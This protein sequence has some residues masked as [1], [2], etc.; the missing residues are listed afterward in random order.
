V[1][2]R[3]VRFRRPRPSL[4]SVRDQQRVELTRV[5]LR[6]IEGQGVS[7]A[8]A[9]ATVYDALRDQARAAMQ[10]MERSHSLQPTDLAHA[11]FLKL[12]RQDRGWPGRERFLATSSRAMRSILVDHAKRR[13]RLKRTATGTKAD[14]DKIH[15]LLV[16]FD[17]RVT[18]ILAVDDALSRLQVR[19][20]RA[21]Q[22]VELRFFGGLEVVEIASSMK[23]PVRT[24]ER[25]WEFA[26]AWLHARLA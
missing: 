24:V 2:A 20:P 22:V 16:A 10:E 13:S 21:A 26:K 6:A 11:A 5:F 15:A 23:I 14:L 17:E 8:E 18:D 1:S 12:A 9:F 19:H 7:S 25:D 4:R 3:R